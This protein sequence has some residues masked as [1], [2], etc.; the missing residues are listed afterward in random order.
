MCGEPTC[1]ADTI[2]TCETKAH[3]PG[4]S[5]CCITAQKATP[6]LCSDYDTLSAAT[7]VCRPSN[8]DCKLPDQW[9]T[10]EGGGDCDSNDCVL[11]EILTKE[12]LRVV[13]HVC[14]QQF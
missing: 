5:V 7:S 10:C 12:G 6:N 9:K 8:A 13:L 14:E 2:W 11:R 1:A 4:S 3:C